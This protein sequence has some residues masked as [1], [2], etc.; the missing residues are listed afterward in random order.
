M[1]N[2]IMKTQS[3]IFASLIWS[4]FAILASGCETIWYNEFVI[5]NSTD[6][7]I[8]ITAFDV[9]GVSFDKINYLEQI[10][11]NAQSKYSV[12]KTYGYHAEEPGVFISEEVDSVVIDF[13]NVMRITQ[14]CNQILGSQCDF[15]SNIM[16]YNNSYDIVKTGKSSG[17]DEFRYTYTITEEDYNNASI[18]EGK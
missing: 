17:R 15:D 13:D 3:K 4:F 5:V 11:I 16:N 1:N 9:N 10:V 12:M 8:V 6:H 14:V 18:I 2:T 7:D